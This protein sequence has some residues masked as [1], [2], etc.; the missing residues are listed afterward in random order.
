MS[1]HDPLWVR[2][3]RWIEESGLPLYISGTLGVHAWAI[4]RKLIELD[5]D[6]NLTP[7]WFIFQVRD[8]SHWTGCPEHQVEKVLTKLEGDEWI[9]RA[10]QSFDIQKACII[11]P[12]EFPTDLEDVRKGLKRDE[13]RGG[14]FILRYSQDVSALSQV[15]KVVYL[16]QMIFGA[17]FTPKI[18]EDLEEI[19]NTY[20]MGVIYDTFSE[21]HLKNVK[22][23]SWV[24]TR[25]HKVAQEEK[26][27]N[28][29][30]W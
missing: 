29:P 1:S 4:F 2:F 5:C 17:R 7:D 27:D 19:A 10:D 24:K 11:T 23:L 21:A 3:P 15:D 22:S 9:K 18:A 28:N 13:S 8:L 30:L 25:L 20:D 6:Q 12:L 26:R 14:N 16:Y